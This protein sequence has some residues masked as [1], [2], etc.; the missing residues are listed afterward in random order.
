MNIKWENWDIEEKENI[1][2]RFIYNFEHYFYP[3][4]KYDLETFCDDLIQEQYIIKSRF[5]YIKTL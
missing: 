2:D 3:H 4:L 5:K 1:Y